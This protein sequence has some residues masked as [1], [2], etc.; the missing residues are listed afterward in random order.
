MQLLYARALLAVQDH[1]RL[2]QRFGEVAARPDASPYLL[3]ILG[4][5]CEQTGDREFAA[6][7]LDRAAKAELASPPVRGQSEPITRPGSFEAFVVAGDDAVLREANDEAVA[8]Y[9]RAMDL[10]YPEWLL[11][12]AVYAAKLSTGAQLAEHYLAA[13]PDSLLAPRLVAGAAM[14]AGDWR[15]ASLLLQNANLRLGHNDPRMLADLAFAQMQSGDAEAAL[16]SAEAAYRL[17]RAS[18]AATQMLGLVLARQRTDP[19][20]AAS[21]LDKAERIAGSNPLIQQ[22][23][24]QLRSR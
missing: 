3:T 24:M 20:R 21:L 15:R 18:P 19:A 1:T 13:F 12:H 22:A 2:W 7:L 16:A 11:D 23:R 6:E 14:R 9:G 8:A 4:R 5:S 10:R 17:Q